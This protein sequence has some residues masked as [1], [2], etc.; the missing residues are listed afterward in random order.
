MKERAIRKGRGWTTTT[1]MTVIILSF[2][3][4]AGCAEVKLGT[5]STPPPTAR[6]RVF[7]K[8]I[9]GDKKGHWTTPH[10]KFEE[11]AYQ[12]AER[13]FVQSGSYEIVPLEEVRLITGNKELPGWQ[14]SRN[15]WALAGEVGRRLYVEY[16][17]IVERSHDPTRYHMF[18]LINVDTK[19]RFEITSII[20]GSSASFEVWNQNY[21]SA[22]AKLFS[23]ANEDLLATAN[24]KS[25]AVSSELAAARKEILEL[26]D[27][28]EKETKTDSP[29]KEKEPASRA[30]TP[31]VD[32]GKDEKVAVLEAKLAK[33]METLTQLEE[34][35]KQFE[36]QREKSDTLARELAE[37]EQREKTLLRK[38][39]DSSKAPPVIVLASPREDSTV[40]VNFVQLSGV[41]E[42]E[43]G[44]KQLEIYINDKPFTKG[45]ERGIRVA[46]KTSTK[47]QEFMERVYLEKGANRLKIRAVDSDGLFTEKTVTVQY[48]E[49][50]KNM[51]A[52]VIG[53][54]QYP[55]IRQLKYAVS[56]A[57]LFYDHL[58]KRNQI[59]AENVV[60]LL[61][62]D[63]TLTKI[64]SVLGTD[65]K[66]KAGKDDMVVIYFAGHGATERDAQ[67]PDGDGLEK[68]LLPFDADLKDLYAT[69]LPMEELSRIFN[70]IRSERL[71]FIADS[72]YS[73]ASGGRTIGMDGMRASISEAFIDRIAGGKGRVIMTASGANEVSAEKDELQHGVFTYFLIEGLKGAADTD[74]DGLVTVDEAYNYV[75]KHVPAATAQEQHPVKRGT[76]EGR[77]VLSVTQ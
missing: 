3:M 72:C 24:R 50:L 46:A 53:I 39:E 56:D 35:K 43:K 63:A 51:W 42:D 34:M 14:W 59:P 37:K 17:L 16:V 36:D 2:F 73:G 19:K 38:L 44:L 77:L 31:A 27:T 7:V 10:E 75:S 65:L 74:R 57:G 11:H 66:N 41:V 6:L 55:H 71:I 23:D 45:S 29:Q 8:A 58:V 26:T 13:F 15:D 28:Q 5:L 25:R 18:L 4:A 61:N 30:K 1:L 68:Y 47:R 70:R 12:N 32:T 9:T 33:L 62:Q 60:L 64:R 48:V 21:R 22:I 54:D 52:V 20:S 49:K 76:V 40:E 67:S 69:A